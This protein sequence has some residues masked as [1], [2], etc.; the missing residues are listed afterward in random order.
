[1]DPFQDFVTSMWHPAGANHVW[2]WANPKQYWRVKMPR[3]L[4]IYDGHRNSVFQKLLRDDI[5]LISATSSSV[6]LHDRW[7]KKTSGECPLVRAI[8]LVAA[9]SWSQGIPL[10]PLRFAARILLCIY[11]CS[12]T[13]FSPISLLLIGYSAESIVNLMQRLDHRQ[14]SSNRAGKLTLHSFARVQY[15]AKIIEQEEKRKVN[16]RA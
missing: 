10:T 4:R 13:S 12:K 6:N 5:F 14:G 7:N 16:N 3:C 2:G 8:W 9:I 11:V 15:C 1:M